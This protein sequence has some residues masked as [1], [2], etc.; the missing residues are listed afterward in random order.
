MSMCALGGIC[1]GLIGDEQLGLMYNQMLSDLNGLPGHGY[2]Q[3]HTCQRRFQ[4]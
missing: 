1:H 3:A 4:K 2:R